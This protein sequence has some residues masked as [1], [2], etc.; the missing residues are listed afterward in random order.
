[1]TRPLRFLAPAFGV[2]VAL[3]LGTASAQ[4]DAAGGRLD[5]LVAVQDRPVRVK[6]GPRA[7]VTELGTVGHDYVELIV[8]DTRAE[9]DAMLRS[10]NTPSI[11]GMDAMPM[12]GGVW[13]VRVG[14]RDS[15]KDL[16]ATIEDGE[17]VLEVVPRTQR[18]RPVVVETANT[19]QLI[20]GELP[21]QP[22]RP[23]PFKLTPLPGDAQSLALQPHD[24]RVVLLPSPQW[25]PRST[26]GA[27][28]R[29]RNTML[30]S[31]QESE[32][33]VRAQYRLGLHYLELGLG[34]EA[35]H[36]FADISKRPGPVAQQEL[37]TARSRAALIC[38]EWDEAR[39]HLAE[40][41]RLGAPES[42]IL[43]GLAVV[44]LA[45]N[46]PP[47]GATGRALALA[48]AH[49][50]ARMLAAELLQRDGYIAETLSI[51][52]G[53][54]EQ[55]RGED[56]RRAALRLGD[57]YMA[58]NNA[59]E[60]IRAWGETSPEIAEMRERW[61]D[62]LLSEP[63]EWPAAI[64]GLVQAS[65]PRTD[66]A[67]EALYLLAQIDIEVPVG[68]REDAINEL[69]AIMRR[70]PA[71]ARGSDVPERFWSVYSSYVQDLAV[72]KRWFDIAA[73]HETVW[74]STARRAVTDGRVLVDVARAYHAVGL[75]DK[76]LQILTEATQFISGSSAE[77]TELILYIADLYGVARQWNEGL[78]S[79]KFLEAQGIDPALRG[80][81]AML[82]ARLH[83]GKG[84]QDAA[85]GALKRAALT[86]EYR[87]EATLE[88]AMLDAEN[89]QCKRAVPTL[90][91]LLFSP[92]AEEGYPDPE[93]WVAL[94]RCLRV[95]G[96]R[97][98]AA[99]A[100]KGAAERT[101][102]DD[103]ARYATWLAASA[104]EWQDA[105]AVDALKE[106]DDIWGLMAK[107][108]QE[109]G[110]FEQELQA[111]RE[112]LWTAGKR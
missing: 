42:G 15:S 103:H 110:A 73:L 102:G 39:E 88:M 57:A 10:R 37:E 100:A 14:L 83:L 17:L 29:A 59:P 96:D 111:R 86:P 68:P 98:G 50:K 11:R 38:G 65:I 13:L 109:A 72:A 44:S 91:R 16:S 104:S 64:P 93:P 46:D 12:S 8:R 40:A 69:A 80:R 5:S 78:K 75:P 25:L 84:D 26:W 21:P 82:E 7:S 92:Q 27:V 62:L 32:T 70:Y 61:I 49:P 99:R 53:L 97:E 81:V 94:S 30:S 2:V 108:H 36:Y 107:E 54:P 41:W 6:V 55:L 79:L 45:T 87:E 56:T 66:G 74:D 48:T 58:A 67:A 4:E 33:E 77:D 35:R 47:R 101:S 28:D 23:V 106:G 90:R 19:E 43:E 76:A 89:G 31:P 95:A 63:R 3:A 34:E 71:K 52:E 112:T 22:L 9:L 18:A 24:Y 85:L 1:M 105:E 20:T 51:L 60:A